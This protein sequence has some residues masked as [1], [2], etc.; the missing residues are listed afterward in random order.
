[1]I[2]DVDVR[3]LKLAFKDTFTTKEDL[4]RLSTE[5]KESLKDLREQIND[6]MDGKLKLQKEATVKEVGEY[7]VDTLVPMFDQRDKKITRIEKKLNLPPL[8]D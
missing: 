3:K 8:V 1:M 5:T 7:I 2:T 6:D 4:K